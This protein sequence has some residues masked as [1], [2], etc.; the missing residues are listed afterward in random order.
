MTSAKNPP[1]TGMLSTTRLRSSTMTSAPSTVKPSVNPRPRTAPLWEL[2]GVV[3][4]RPAF[5][6]GAAFSA[7]SGGGWALTLVTALLIA[8]LAGWLIARPERQP[9]WARVGLWLIIGGGLGNLYDRIAYGGVTDFI[10]LRFVRFA[11]FNLA[12]VA[13]CLGAVIAAVALLIDER[14]KESAHV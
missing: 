5:N 9:K 1:I 14:R 10:E 13:I 6:T 4:I 11:V 12:D 8:L 2:P 3:S 7:F